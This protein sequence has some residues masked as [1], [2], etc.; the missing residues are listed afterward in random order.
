[1]S[2]LIMNSVLFNINFDKEPF[3]KEAIFNQNEVN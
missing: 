3:S 2:H 1:M